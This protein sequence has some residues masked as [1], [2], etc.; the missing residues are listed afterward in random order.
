MNPQPET[1]RARIA[2]IEDDPVMGGSLQQRLTLEG[3]AV[4]W[5]RNGNEARAALAGNAPDGIVCDIRL[6]DADGE[7]LFARLKPLAPSAP[8]IFITGFGEVDQAVRLVKA[9]ATDYLTKPFEVHTLLDQL[10]RCVRPTEPAGTLGASAAM[11]SVE[12]LL[13]RVA[14]LDSTLLI[15]GET[16]VGKEV[17]ARLVHT[18]SSRCA[19]P[20]VAVNC[21]A[22]PD[23]LIEGELFGYE[24]GAFTGADRQH[25][26][27]LARARDG[28]LFLDE[29]GDLPISTQ[30]KLLRVLQEREFS[31]LGAS[32]PQRLEARVVCATHRDLPAM[33]RD[34]RFREDLY[35]RIAVI[36]VVIPPLRDRSGDVL[37]MLGSMV[38]EFAKAFGRDIHG[39]ADDVPLRIAAHGWPGNVREL[40]NRAERAVALCDGNLVAVSDLFPDDCKAPSGK[41]GFPTLAQA[42]EVAE[43]I[44]IARALEVTGG[45]IEEAAR[46][47]GVSRSV[48]FD[49]IRRHRTQSGFPD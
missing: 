46:K 39:L 14:D 35:Y 6:P 33:V 7:A 4:E 5:H 26:G 24:R 18:R 1:V 30:A 49:K 3:Y 38:A 12:G 43:R 34:G 8:F 15:T 28:T 19:S 32:R 9:G 13:K 17:A 40:R 27:Y 16:G 36:P 37:P 20:F 44:H 42:R 31:R 47:L 41:E 22:I 2:L 10:A 48:M 25:E 45:K 29:I 11:R 21:V 23:A